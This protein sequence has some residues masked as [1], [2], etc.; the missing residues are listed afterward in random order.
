MLEQVNA[1]AAREDVPGAR[2]EISI[3]SEFVPLKQSEASKSLYEL[4]RGA[5]RDVGF[6]VEG[7]FSGGCADSGFT[8]EVGA[9]TLCGTGAIGGNFHSKD[10]YIELASLVPRAQ[11]LAFAALRRLNV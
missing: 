6:E 1:V 10:E 9:P 8:S 4:Y 5:A 3:L 11:A 2:A 7:D